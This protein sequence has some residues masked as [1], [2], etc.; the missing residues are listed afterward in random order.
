MKNPFEYFSSF[1]ILQYFEI[2]INKPSRLLQISLSYPF[3]KINFEFRAP[4]GL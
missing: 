4:F 2:K 1:R 3:Q